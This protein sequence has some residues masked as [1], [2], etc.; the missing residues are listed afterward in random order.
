MV[1]LRLFEL[2]Y[3]VGRQLWPI[4]RDGRLVEHG[5]QRKRWPNAMTLRARSVSQPT[6]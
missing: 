3:V 4:D 5:G 1:P 2:L 6:L